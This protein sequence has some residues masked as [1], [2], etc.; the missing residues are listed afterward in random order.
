MVLEVRVLA[1]SDR[2]LQIDTT[3]IDVL[4]LA[5]EK[6]RIEA[7]TGHWRVFVLIDMILCSKLAI[8]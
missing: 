1:R 6:L 8:S 7:R 3:T 2:R 5:K 4:K